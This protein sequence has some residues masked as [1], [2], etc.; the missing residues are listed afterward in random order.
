MDWLG[1][2]LLSRSSVFGVQHFFTQVLSEVLQVLHC[3]SYTTASGV[4]TFVE[5][6]H[7]GF[8]VC[9]CLFDGFKNFAH[10]I[11]R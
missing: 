9:N 7:V 1:R 8:C 6:F 3:F 5:F 2:E 4:V 11:N 10:N